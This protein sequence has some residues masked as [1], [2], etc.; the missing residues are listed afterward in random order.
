MPTRRDVLSTVL[1]SSSLIALGPS[2]PGFLARSA[3]GAGPERDGRALVVI[4]L[5]GGNDGIN[6]VVPFGDE[7]YGRN[8]K[9]LKLAGDRLIKVSDGVGLHPSM[10]GAGK[11]LESGRLAIVPGVGYPEPRAARTSR[12]SRDLADRPG[13]IPAD[14][15]GHRLDRPRPG[16][17]PAPRRRRAGKAA[18]L[19]VGTGHDRPPRV[20]GRR[21]STSRLE[22][23]RGPDDRLRHSWT[24]SVSAGAPSADD[25]SATTSV[26]ASLD[27]YADGRSA[28]IELAHAKRHL[29]TTY[30]EGPL[31][32]I[33]CGW[34]LG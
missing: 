7:G 12:A 17:R 31:S 25:L 2:V 21:A 16:R 30:P 8:R 14:R 26:A 9:A 28:R 3:R 4:Q 33:A 32:P 22:L 29:G 24:T 15:D 5:E 20:R 11:L 34:P 6:M 10:G 13:S 1:R 18:C 19:L 23:D 27:A